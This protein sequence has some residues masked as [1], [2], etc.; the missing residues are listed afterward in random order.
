MG[1]HQLLN[2]RHRKRKQPREA[3]FS[4]TAHAPQPGAPAEI[5]ITVELSSYAWTRLVTAAS[6]A[7]FAAALAPDLS[8]FGED[9]WGGV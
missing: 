7:E 2:V 6:P 3:R 1:Q 5:T 8:H 4:L 9:V